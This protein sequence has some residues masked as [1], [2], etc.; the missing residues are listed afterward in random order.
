LA[1]FVL[2]QTGAHLPYE[3]EV[4]GVTL[5]LHHFHQQMMDLE[6]WYL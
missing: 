5:N 6:V 1:Y 4:G 2:P 3:R